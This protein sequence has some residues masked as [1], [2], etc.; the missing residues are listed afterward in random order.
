M[1]V[2][3]YAIIQKGYYPGM[4]S[5]IILYIPISIYAYYYYLIS[6][7]ITWLQAGISFI[8]GIIYGISNDICINKSEN[9]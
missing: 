9:W 5:G 1:D 4:V 7:K 2:P 3:V 8:L 6:N